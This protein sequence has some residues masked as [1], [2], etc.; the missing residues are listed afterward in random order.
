MDYYDE[1]NSRS[2]DSLKSCCLCLLFAAITILLC[3][4][5]SCRSVKNGTSENKETSDSVRTE[6][7]EKI[8]KVPVIV[9]VEVPV[10]VKDR[11]TRDSTSTLETS[12]AVSEAS[13]IWVGGVPFLR[14]S[15]ENKAQKIQK[16]DSVPV[17]EKETVKWNTRRVFYTKTQ[18]L[19]QQLSWWQKGLMWSGAIGWCIVIIFVIIA[20]RNKLF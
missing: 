1:K 11:I 10:E 8:V 15:L 13:I 7:K 14:H 16:P 3:L 9:E 5:C 4:F 18:I 2:G 20:F 17:T 12:F 6:Y 19:E